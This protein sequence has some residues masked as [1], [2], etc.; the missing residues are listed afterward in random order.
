MVYDRGESFYGHVHRHPARMWY[1]HHARRDGT[2]VKVEARLMLDGGA[3]ASTSAAV[4]AN[5]C[6]FSAGP[7]LV[8]NAVIEGWAMRTNNPPCGAMRGFGAV[9]TCFAHEAQMDRLAAAIGLDPIEL[10]LR[11]AL[12]PGD[13]L[14]TGQRIDGTAPVADIIRAVADHPEPAHPEPA[15]PEPARTAL[16]LP[17]GTGLT[18]DPVDVRR[19]TAI[20]VGFKNLMFSEGYDDFSTASVALARRCGDGEV[21]VC[22]GRTGFRHA[23]PADRARGVGDR[24]GR[25]RTRRH[26]H[27]IGRFDVGVE[28]DLDVGGRG[29]AGRR[30]GAGTTPRRGRRPVG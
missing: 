28:T 17:G 7:Y 10:R 14:L 13:R 8:P 30:G 19:G 4:L 12:K 1:R 20:A 18:T 3:Y 27:R 16:E 2:L 26:V 6:C 15:Q 22:G 21:C 25:D 23:G 11:N 24:R 9:Q 5:A 29:H